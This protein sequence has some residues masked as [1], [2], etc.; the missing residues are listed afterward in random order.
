MLMLK[1]STLRFIG[2]LVLMVSTTTVTIQAKVKPNNL[3]ADNMVLQQKQD[4]LALW[5]TSTPSKRM[6]L[7]TS[8]NGQSYSTTTDTSGQWMLRIST[9]EAGG[10]YSLT[11][12]DGETTTLS[13]VLIG[14]VW[15][16]SGQSNMEMPMMGYPE[17]PLGA[18]TS[19]DDVIRSKNPQLRLLS[20]ER[21]AAVEPKVEVSGKWKEAGPET[22]APFSAVGY[23]FGRMLQE[24]LGVP[25]GIVCTSWGGSRI[26][27]WMSADMLSEYK[28]IAIPSDMSQV[29]DPT[30]SP[31]VIYNGMIHP[32]LRMSMRGFIWYQGESNNGQADRY[33]TL[34]RQFIT[35]LRKKWAIGDFPFY[36]CQIAPFVYWGWGN[37]AFLRE[38]QLKVESMVPNVGMAVL[39]DAGS[40]DCIHPARKRVVGERL[41]QQALVRTYGFSGIPA[42]S[43][44]YRGMVV[45]GDTIVLSFDRAPLGLTSYYKT[46]KLFTLAGSNQKFYPAK[47]W[48]DKDRVFV[49][50][51]S[52]SNPVAARYAFDNY[53][54]GELFGVEGLPVSSFRTDDFPGE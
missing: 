27:T 17:Q 10:P 40:K 23:Y 8:W 24:I 41:C 47:A 1:Y 9:P 4:S 49:I 38:A 54:E 18:D 42:Q 37:S 6:T 34:F 25:V 44:V 28:D 43:P 16:C 19:I 2:I 13:N 12:E 14:E 21:H 48:I 39:M 11:F 46:L 53:V 36:Y 45:K 35:D 50:S 32:L 7:I 30:Q 33:V 20:V 15:I 51:D 31:T 29:K 52:V 26:E 3:F 22:V 5:G